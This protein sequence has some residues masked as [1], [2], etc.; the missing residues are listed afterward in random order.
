MKVLGYADDLALIDSTVEAMTERLT[1]MVDA[2]RAEADMEVSMPKTFSQNVHKREAI[3]TT[4]SEAKA[5]EKKY[6]HKCD[7]CSRR[8]KTEINM[9]KHRAHCIYN[10]GTTDEIYEVEKIVDVFGHASSRWFLVKWVGYEE[11]PRL[12]A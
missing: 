2:S 9:M 1:R 12:T 8:F 3:K 10:Y 11:L 4:T 5:M 6:K 7:F